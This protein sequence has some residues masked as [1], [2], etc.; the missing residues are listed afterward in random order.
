MDSI[1]S[2]KA[3][4]EQK[5]KVADHL[6]STTYSF[7]KEPKLL[8][9]VIENLYHALEYAMTGLLEHEKNMHTISDY[10]TSFEEKFEIF[11]RKLAPK[12]DISKELLGFIT[13]LKNTLEEHKKS[14]LEFAKKEK[15]VISDNDYNLRTL[16]VDEVKKKLVQTKKYVD[17][18]FALVKK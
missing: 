13:E 17:E 11:R 5:I 15:F 14:S 2:F 6:L 1:N 10:G 3:Q 12:H 16:S 4:A 18:L 8:V 7:V 9:S